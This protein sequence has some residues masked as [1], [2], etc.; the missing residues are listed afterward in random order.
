MGSEFPYPVTI[1][2]FTLFLLIALV[3]PRLPLWARLLIQVV[4][5]LGIYFGFKEKEFMMPMA[6][7]LPMSSLYGG[8]GG[9]GA[10]NK[11]ALGFLAP[12]LGVVFSLVVG[13]VRAL[14]SRK[15]A[16]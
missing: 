13:A 6:D 16:D 3:P 5:G 7:S 1:A 15:S 2:V 9:M 11:L 8:D 10:F 14:I 12:V 4:L